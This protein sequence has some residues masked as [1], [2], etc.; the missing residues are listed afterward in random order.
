[1]STSL[2]SDDRVKNV[3][4]NTTSIALDVA[5]NQ[6]AII[7]ASSASKHRGM[8]VKSAGVAVTYIVTYT[9][10]AVPDINNIV[11]ELNATMYGQ[12]FTSN[13]QS[14]ALASNDTVFS[15]LVFG[16]VINIT[17]TEVI[18]VST[19]TPTSSNSNKSSEG[20][21][22]MIPLAALALIPFIAL[23]AYG[24]MYRG[25]FHKNKGLNAEATIHGNEL[26]T[27]T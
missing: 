6:V 26:M 16:L 21:T 19:G 27:P 4:I 24:V 9:K 7:S 10:I 14:F 15:N 3:F 8:Q 12:S 22:S 23:I 5:Y 2:F 11:A 1:M 20:A 17:T 18:L 13:L 25:W